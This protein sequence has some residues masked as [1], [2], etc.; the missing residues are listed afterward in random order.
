MQSLLDGIQEGRIRLNSNGDEI[1]LEPSTLF[2]FTVKA[3]KKGD[4]TKL[5]VKISWS[6]TKKVN[7]TPDSGLEISS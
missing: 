4:T 6:D 3:R 1:V 5:S 7:V 2:K